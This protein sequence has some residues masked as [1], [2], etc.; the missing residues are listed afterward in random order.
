VDIVDPAR[1][2]VELKAEDP[3]PRWSLEICRSLGASDEG[4]ISQRDTYFNVSTG[5]LKLREE[6]P[7]APHLVQ[8]NRA[9][10]PRQRLSSYRIVAVKDSGT[11]RAALA[12]SLGELGVVTKRRHLLLWKSVRIHLD[13]VEGL[14]RFIE[15]EAV[16]PTDSDLAHEHELVAELRD[17][18]RITDDRLCATGYA[19]QLF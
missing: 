16:A 15:L 9:S 6:S 4:S 18:L 12:E 1:R 14:G 8:F 17:A 10:E 3:D 7:G 19:E 13:D 2:N 5:G 11:L